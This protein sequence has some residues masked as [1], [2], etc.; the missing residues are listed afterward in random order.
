MEDIA[1]TAVTLVAIWVF[2]S[3]LMHVGGKD[4]TL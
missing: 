4:E 2:L 3:V 1:T